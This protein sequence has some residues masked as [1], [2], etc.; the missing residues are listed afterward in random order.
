MDAIRTL[1]ANVE[2]NEVDTMLGG[3]VHDYLKALNGKKW[4]WTVDK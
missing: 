4:L 3:G 2:F 1:S